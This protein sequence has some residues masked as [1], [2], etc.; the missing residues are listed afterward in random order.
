MKLAHAILFMVGVAIA[1]AAA[2]YWVG[3]RQ[4]D[5]TAAFTIAGR[6]LTSVAYLESIW[7]GKINEQVML[8]E[9]DIDHALVANH[10]LEQ[11]LGFRLL[12]PLRRSDAEAS[13]RERL[14]R[15]ANY[16]KGHLSPYRPEA[17]EGLLRAQIPESERK[18]LPELTPALLESMLE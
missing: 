13:R 18:N 8:M 5:E 7:D 3:L 16:R 4:G 6:A 14:T 9:S 17:L 11:S 15:L 2:G 1:A 12:T 10:Y